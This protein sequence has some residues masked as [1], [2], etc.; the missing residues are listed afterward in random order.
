MTALA[1]TLEEVQVQILQG[2]LSKNPKLQP[3][4]I[5]SKDKEL[6]TTAKKIIPAINELLKH[7]NVLDNTVA[8]YS[9]KVQTLVDAAEASLMQAIAERV[10]EIEG[11][12]DIK[13]DEGLK[14]VI[15]EQVN[16]QIA[17]YV[18]TTMSSQLEL[19]LKD[20]LEAFFES[21]VTSYIDEKIQELESKINASGGEGGEAMKRVFR[22]KITIATNSTATLPWKFHEIID[23]RQQIVVTENSTIGSGYVV[24][25][26]P[27]VLTHESGS[28]YKLYSAPADLRVR[29][30]ESITITNKGVNT[31]IIYL[32]D[33]V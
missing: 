4:P 17:E 3:S 22:E 19:M 20:R 15:G 24:I 8:D 27:Y 32:Y 30:D 23:L 7:I 29:K 25:D 33:L 13:I 10:V 31:M 2:D 16:M 14:N 1:E 6:K 28:L 26:E 21:N 9:T 11:D 5:P 12:M 18:K